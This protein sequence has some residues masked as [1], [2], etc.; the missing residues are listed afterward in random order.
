MMQL[1]YEQALSCTLWA[2][3]GREFL[4]AMEETGAAALR[5][6]GGLTATP[7]SKIKALFAAE[8]PYKQPKV[9]QPLQDLTLH[10]RHVQSPGR[11]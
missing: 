7:S 3:S 5:Y 10:V 6:T 4:C 2:L 11:K 8:C 1:I 9:L